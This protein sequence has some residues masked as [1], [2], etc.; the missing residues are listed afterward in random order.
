MSSNTNLE[1][2]TVIIPEEGA[3]AILNNEYRE[4]TDLVNIIIREGVTEIEYYAFYGCSNLV[5]VTLPQGL[6]KIGS[7]AFNGCTSLTSINLPDSIENIDSYAFN[8]CTALSD[9]K[10]PSSLK[11][12]GDSVFANCT[13]LK[14]VELPPLLSSIGG[15]TFPKETEIL[16]SPEHQN[17]K[18]ENDMILSANGKELFICR[19]NS[20]NIT[21]PSSVT[22]IGTRVFAKN[23]HIKNITIP[24]NVKSLGKFCFESCPSLENVILENGVEEIMEYA[25]YKCPKLETISFPISLKR[26]GE[27][28]FIECTSLKE[29]NIPLNVK[30]IGE[31]AFN[32]TGVT[33]VTIDAK[34]K[35]SKHAFNQC[36]N[37]TTAVLACKSIAYHAFYGCSS[38]Q[39]VVFQKT[40]ERVT[41]GAF[42]NCKRLK[43]VYIDRLNKTIDGQHFVDHNNAKDI[44]LDVESPWMNVTKSDFN[45]I[46]EQAKQGDAK[47]QKDLGDCYYKGEGI[48]KNYAA[49]A[50]CYLLSAKQG[51]APAQFSLALCYIYGNGV[52]CSNKLAFEWAR[53]AAKQGHSGAQVLLGNFY[54]D[55]EYVIRDYETAAKWYRRAIKNG[56]QTAAEKLDYLTRKNLILPSNAVKQIDEIFGTI[57][58]NGK[59]KWICKTTHTFNSKE[60]PFDI[61][62]KGTLN[63]GITDVQRIAYANYLQMKDAYFEELQQKAKKLYRGANRKTK[64]ILL[65]IALYID[66]SGNY[67][68]K[69]HKTWGGTSNAAILSD[70]PVQMAEGNNILYHYDDVIASRTNK[71]WHIDDS[72]YLTLFGEITEVNICNSRDEENDNK[73]TKK[74]T[75]LLMW[76]TTQLD[77][78]TI[79]QDVIDYC[80]I[81]YE[82][83][84]DK[85][86]EAEDVID[87]VS[88]NSIYLDVEFAEEC[89]HRPEIFLAGECKADDEHGISIGFKNKKLMEISE[90]GNAF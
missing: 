56:N 90:E 40:V 85:R 37:L 8:G 24:H 73:L 80:N 54:S 14:K 17:L 15:D 4:N 45:S 21:I 69:C 30:E 43:T 44:E 87:E 49:A 13:N 42:S 51:Y 68:W 52:D 27:N 6:K 12:I 48:E 74:E 57:I 25:F 60:I 86:I 16:I 38:L 76:L 35:L 1:K 79:K 41:I 10:L 55:G 11:T 82:M 22:S 5:S 63:E 59:D 32:S 19:S 3:K 77:T 67:G 71:D 39:S 81:N 65:P 84:S 78:E 72:T 28:A 20:D 36:P 64:N 26:I 9:I 18:K 34:C 31:D 53:A 7:Y 89:N 33:Q 66:R 29:V 83:W 23:Q 70:G 50:K 46:R 61:E 88:I 47:V 62:L 58:Y 2:N 75:E